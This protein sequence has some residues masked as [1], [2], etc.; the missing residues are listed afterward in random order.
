MVLFAFSLKTRSAMNND[1]TQIAGGRLKELD[2]IRGI[3]AI[4]IIIFHFPRWNVAFDF[5]VIRNA[6]IVVDVFFIISGFVICQVYRNAITSVRDLLRF[7]FLRLGRL[8]PVHFVFLILFIA[9]ES[10][11]YLAEKKFGIASPNAQAFSGNSASAILQQ[12]FMAHAIGPTGNATTFN[13]P[14]WSISVEF[15]TYIIF[16]LC[17]LLCGQAKNLLFIFFAVASLALILSDMT[18]G[19]DEL[20]RCV[21]GFFIGCLLASV[22]DR[23]NI[24]LPTYASMLVAIAFIVFLGVKGQRQG[25]WLVYIFAAAFMLTVIL[26]RNG[27]LNNILN[28]RPVAWLGDISYSLYMSHALVIWAANQVVRVIFKKPEVMIDGYS[29]PQLN[30]IETGFAFAIVMLLVL[31]VSAC[32]YRFIEAPLR[33]RSRSLAFSVAKGK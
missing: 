20:L 19:F 18:F 16:S 14:S 12:L 29:T 4:F 9:V 22:A 10:A 32:V 23:L 21:A 31:A 5:S 30:L 26:V 17:I 1:H 28:R 33:E 25:D 3:L 13:R 6:Y 24:K 15:Y 27:L 8:Y 7:Q 11:K 2:G